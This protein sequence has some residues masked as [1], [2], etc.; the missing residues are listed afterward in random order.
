MADLA[1]TP[2]TTNFLKFLHKG[3]S[4]RELFLKGI[5]LKVVSK[6]L[7]AIKYDFYHKGKSVDID[8]RSIIDG[9]KYI[10]IGDRVWVQRGAWLTVPLIEIN[11]VENRPYLIIGEGTRIGPHSTIS[12]ANRIYIGQNVLFGLNVTVVDH[13]HQYREITK[14]I[15][16]QG[17]FSDGEIIIEDN[18]WLGANS[19]IYSARK[20]L[21]IGKNCV[22][23]ANS[24]VRDD[25]KPFSVVSGNPA[26][27]IKQYSFATKVWENLGEH[28]KIS[29]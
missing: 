28:E 27:I 3:Y 18:A 19:I 2:K 10:S 29:H 7:S 16:H 6:V 5:S 12:A 21:V 4:F 11:N 24:F 9:A 13:M 17:I 15:S 23:A 25:V 8:Y 1:L 26:K 20:K 22:V 14:P